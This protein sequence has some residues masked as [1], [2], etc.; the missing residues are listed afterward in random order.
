[1]IGNVTNLASRL[2]DEARD[3]QILIASRVRAAIEHAVETVPMGDFSLKGFSK[4]VATYNVVGLKETV[5]SPP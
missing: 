3:G 2:C 4:P 1:V 5:P